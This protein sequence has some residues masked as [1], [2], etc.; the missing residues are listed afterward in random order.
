MTATTLPALLQAFFTDRLLRQRQASPHT[1]AAYRDTFR[2]LLCFAQRRTDKPPCKL[3][4]EELDAPRITLGMQATVTADGLPGQSFKGHVISISPRMD[5]KSIHSDRPFELYDTKVR[6][7]LV[8]LD[9][10]ELL[11]IGLRVDVTFDA[12]GESGAETAG[13]PLAV[14]TVWTER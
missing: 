7:V 6:E 3:Q 14:T 2:L 4:I 11:I 13:K 10:K 5:T 8:E 1:I 12:P 9:T